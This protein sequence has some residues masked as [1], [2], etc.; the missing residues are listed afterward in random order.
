MIGLGTAALLGLLRRESSVHELVCEPR[1]R[2]AEARVVGILDN[3]LE[4]RF[5]KRVWERF[6]DGLGRSP[7]CASHMGL[8]RVRAGVGRRRI[9]ELPRKESQSSLRDTEIGRI[10]DS[11][12]RYFEESR[13]TEPETTKGNSLRERVEETWHVL[14]HPIP[15]PQL[16]NEAEETEYESHPQLDVSPASPICIREL[17][18]RWAAHDEVGAGDVRLLDLEHVLR[19]DGRLRVIDPM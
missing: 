3:A 12:L 14:H 4:R 10:E 6:D 2:H 11:S 15:R 5:S 16:M 19:G 8:D 18:A 13:L 9:R 1:L 7:R 17:R